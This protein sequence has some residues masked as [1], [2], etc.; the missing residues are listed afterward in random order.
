MHA[1]QSQHS[2]PALFVAEHDYI[3]AEDSSSLWF[4]LKLRVKADRLPVAP[5]HFPRRRPRPDA[6]QHVVFFFTERHED[7][8]FLRLRNAV[9]R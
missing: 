3:F 7:L 5:Q 6:G 2:N 8:S 4:V 1:T 9:A